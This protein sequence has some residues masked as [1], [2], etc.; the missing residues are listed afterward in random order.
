[1]LPVPIQA[2]I[3]DQNGRIEADL[4]VEHLVRIDR[5]ERLLPATNTLHEA[6]SYQNTPHAG[7]GAAVVEKGHE[8]TRRWH[9]DVRRDAVLA[10]GPVPALI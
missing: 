9:N 2:G 5:L 1:M 8:H 7:H 6:A 10:P 4:R 3:H